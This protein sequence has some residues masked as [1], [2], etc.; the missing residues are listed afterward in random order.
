MGSFATILLI[1]G[2]ALLVYAAWSDMTRRILPNV[3]SLTTAASGLAYAAA[4]GG[5]PSLTNHAIHAAIAFVVGILL[6]AMKLWGGGDGKFY[7]GVAAWFPYNHFFALMFA[8]S[9]IGVVL[10]MVLL[11]RHRGKR[12]IQIGA[13]PYGV[14]IALGAAALM[15]V[16][17]V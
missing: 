17:L 13:V 6:F 3:V 15:S 5:T 1:L 14:A 8:V 12:L 10:M 2:G 11:F 9:L 4:T 7:A 16:K